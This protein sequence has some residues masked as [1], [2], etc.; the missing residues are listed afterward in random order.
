MPE[1][2]RILSVIDGLGFAGDESRLLSFAKTVDRDR[3]EHSVLTLNPL[4]YT[5]DDQ[6]RARREHFLR[7]GIR[8]D[9]LSDVMPEKQH[10]FRA[11]PGRLYG[12][13]GLLRRA[14]RLAGVIRKW[15][16]D[17][18]DGHLDSAGLVTALAG[19]I[20][21]KSSSITIYC[22]ERIGEKVIW[23]RPTRVA[24]RLATG[25]LT[26][27]QIRANEMRSLM[28]RQA[29]KVAVIPN[30]ISRPNSSRSP[31]EMRRLL[32]LPE[33][34]A[35]RIIGMVGRFVAYKGHRVL[36]QAACKVLEREPDICFLAV[37][38]TPSGD[39]RESLKKLANDLGIAERVVL[40][41]YPD[42]IADVWNVIDLHVHASLFDSLPI[43]IAE[44][45]SL[46]K[47]AVVTSAGGIPEI[48]KNRETGLVVPPDDADALA[49]GLLELLT[50][51]DLAHRL[52]ANARRRYE[53][54]Y[55]PEQMTR[56]ME[57]YFLNLS[58]HKGQTGKAVAAAA[59]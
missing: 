13:T 40:T 58:N 5:S 43:S 7:A 59:R 42:D 19:R 16:V 57:Q 25:I 54:F 53:T 18:V 12:K 32:G 44:G 33:N 48:V 27:S 51:P 4:A 9:D 39:Y 34:P 14:H 23:P 38:F 49:A 36:I 41:E 29:G 22:G 37:G 45:M 10:D 24:L 3:F 46:G 31:L 8:V 50:K 17:V 20:T 55:R 1:R 21:K 26:D 52:S 15:S 35:I 30:G 28:P 47:P 11:V 56:A 2:T 6:F